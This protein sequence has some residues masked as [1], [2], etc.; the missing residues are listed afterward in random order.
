MVHSRGNAWVFAPINARGKA[1]GFNSGKRSV[2]VFRDEDLATKPNS[3]AQRTLGNTEKRGGFGL[4]ANLGKIFQ[5]DP[6]H[7]QPSKEN[8]AKIVPMAFSYSN[9]FGIC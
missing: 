7:G 9:T 5:V 6:F 2:N 8:F 4:T 1:S 3:F